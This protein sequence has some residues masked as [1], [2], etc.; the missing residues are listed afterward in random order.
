MPKQAKKIEDRTL[1]FNEE[2]ERMIKDGTFPGND[3]MAE[4][5]G[6]PSKTSIS[7]IKSLRQNI[8][9]EQWAKFK[10]HY[11]ISEGSEKSV[12]R[13]KIDAM[14]MRLIE[15]QAQINVLQLT[16]VAYISPDKKSTAAVSAKLKKAILDEID[17]LKREFAG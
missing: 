15:L 12:P 17:S 13:G 5:I 2:I 10:N 7:E 14:Q 4:L 3:A 1:R 8:Q 11:K 6:A 16:L 9:P